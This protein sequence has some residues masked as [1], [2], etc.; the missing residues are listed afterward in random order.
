MTTSVFGMDA[1]YGTSPMVIIL[2]TES[3]FRGPTFQATLTHGAMM[4]I[5]RYSTSLGKRSARASGTLRHSDEY[6]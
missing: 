2:T 1:M 3:P 6:L 5:M 4:D